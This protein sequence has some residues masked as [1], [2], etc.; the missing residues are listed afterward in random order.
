MAVKREILR[1]NDCPIVILLCAKFLHGN[2]LC[3][4][5]HVHPK[6][7]PCPLWSTRP[8]E[9]GSVKGGKWLCH[10]LFDKQGMFPLVSASLMLAMLSRKPVSS[11]PGDAKCC[12]KT[13]EVCVCPKDV[14]ERNYAGCV[15]A[16][17]NG[18]DFR[19]RVV[20][21][22]LSADFL[23]LYSAEFSSLQSQNWSVDW[24]HANVRFTFV[25]KGSK[26]GH[27]HEGSWKERTLFS[28][29]NK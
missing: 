8:S 10:C 11:S 23:S 26:L 19:L 24:C 4:F 6:I 3:F 1:Q 18:H 17:D 21:K 5:T 27:F 9:P 29:P 15:T 22:C 7:K 28:E 2:H 16:N 20:F 12:M 13:C 14:L 25:R